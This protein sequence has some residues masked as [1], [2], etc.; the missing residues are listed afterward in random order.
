MYVQMLTTLLCGS[1]SATW[2]KKTHEGRVEFRRGFRLA[3][4]ELARV[5]STI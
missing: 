3:W 2:Q 5:P 1:R 4:G